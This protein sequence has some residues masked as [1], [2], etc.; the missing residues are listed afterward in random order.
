MGI[1]FQ[2]CVVIDVHVRTIRHACTVRRTV[3]KI[4]NT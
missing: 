3:I 4:L 2:M 1:N